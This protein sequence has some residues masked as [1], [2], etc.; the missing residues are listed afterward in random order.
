MKLHKLIDKLLTGQM[1][2][3]SEVEFLSNPQYA[4]E[5]IKLDTDDLIT[6]SY[7]AVLKFGEPKLSIIYEYDFVNDIFKYSPQRAKPVCIKE[8]EVTKIEH[9]WEYINET[10]TDQD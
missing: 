5:T 1:L 4:I 10:N 3:E 6:D 9:T 8:Y 7:M 2:N